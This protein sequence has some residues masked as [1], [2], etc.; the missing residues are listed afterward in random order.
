MVILYR[1]TVAGLADKV[2]CLSILLY[3]ER[4]FLGQA[5]VLVM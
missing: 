4:N 2:M 1:L 3:N 5:A